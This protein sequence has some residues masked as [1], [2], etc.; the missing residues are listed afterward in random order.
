[1][2]PPR[3][4]SLDPGLS[5]LCSAL[6]G[7][8]PDF[9]LLSLFA[10]VSGPVLSS[11]GGASFLDSPLGPAPTIALGLCW[12]PGR[13]SDPLPDPPLTPQLLQPLPPMLASPLSNVAG[14]LT[15]PNS[16]FVQSF[17]FSTNTYFEMS[18]G[19]QRSCKDSREGAICPSQTTLPWGVSVTAGTV[20]WGRCIQIS[21][22]PP[23]TVS[24]FCP[25]VPHFVQL[26]HVLS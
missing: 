25:R 7:T 21:L 22:A 4:T 18:W 16:C 14:A 20:T 19:L 9:F 24:F 13:Y 15:R 6:P 10:W 1:M 2:W 11:E 12:A 23:P 8:F 17:F 26:S 3:E 5:S